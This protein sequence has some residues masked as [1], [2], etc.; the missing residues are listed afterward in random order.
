VAVSNQDTIPVEIP[1]IYDWL[2]EGKSPI[3]GMGSCH[4]HHIRL[5]KK[6]FL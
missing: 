2:A 1:D 5:L 3:D 6:V 4:N